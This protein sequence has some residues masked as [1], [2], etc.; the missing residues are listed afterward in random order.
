MPR[1]LPQ[2]H[3]GLVWRGHLT[4]VHHVLTAL[5]SRARGDSLVWEGTGTARKSN[6]M[7]TTSPLRPAPALLTYG[8][9][10]THSFQRP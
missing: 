9:G 1:G 6:T 10:E 7:T 8:A 3:H 5:T 4:C 2:Q